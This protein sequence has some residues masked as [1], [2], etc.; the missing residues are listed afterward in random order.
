MAYK[1]VCYAGR[2]VLKLSTGKVSLPDE[3]Q[4][5]RFTENGWLLRDVIARRRE[6]L[7]GSEPLLQKVMDHG[8][9]LGP[10]P[11]LDEIRGRFLGEFAR[12]DQQYKAIR[13]P[14]PYPVGGVES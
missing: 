5:F 9:T 10:L 14:A 8:R 3:K 1:V 2:P 13:D 11:S 4:V 7:A 6:D 12:L